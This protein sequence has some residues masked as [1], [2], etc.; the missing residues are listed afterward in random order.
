MVNMNN[1][2]YRNNKNFINNMNNIANKRVYR[3]YILIDGTKHRNNVCTFLMQK[4]R[5]NCLV[6]LLMLVH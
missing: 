6:F 5:Q 4:S 2:N 1:L 3:I